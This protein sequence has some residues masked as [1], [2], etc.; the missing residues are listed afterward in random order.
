MTILRRLSLAAA[1]AAASL[2]LTAAPSSAVV[3]GSN[4]SAG[5]FPSIAEV[6]LGN[7][8]LCTGTL[9]SPTVVLTAGHCGSI[10]GAA[11]S[12]PAAWPA[13]A[14]DVHVGGLHPGEGD[15]PAVS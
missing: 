3:G 1:A 8:F 7:A 12:T 11:V 2:V 4:A 10:T 15:H 13:A 9:I 14:I 6:I 5:E